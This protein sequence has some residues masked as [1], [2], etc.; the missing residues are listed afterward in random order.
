[1]PYVIV[2]TD[3]RGD[4]RVKNKITFQSLFSGFY[5]DGPRVQEKF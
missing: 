5:T 3:A 2:V 4:N 1:M